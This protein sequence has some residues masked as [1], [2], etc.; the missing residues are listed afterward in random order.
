MNKIYV[1]SIDSVVQNTDFIITTNKKNRLGFENY[2]NLK[3]IDEGKHVLYII[4]P[5]KD[6]LDK[7]SKTRHISDN[8]FLVLQ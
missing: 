1:V 2:I 6:K 3:K 7:E 4:G 5:T 8:T